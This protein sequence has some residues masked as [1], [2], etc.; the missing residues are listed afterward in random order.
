MAELCC[1]TDVALHRLLPLPVGPRETAP[2]SGSCAQH[3]ARRGECR[4]ALHG[5]PPAVIEH[6]RPARAVAAAGGPLEVA[7]SAPNFCRSTLKKCSNEHCSERPKEC[8]VCCVNFLVQEGKALGY[9]LKRI[10]ILPPNS[11]TQ[12]RSRRSHPR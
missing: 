7:A 10:E 3:S 4:R 1:V 5:P 12:G 6:V 9:S 11:S 2:S 8:E